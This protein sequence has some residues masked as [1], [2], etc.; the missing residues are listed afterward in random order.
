MKLQHTLVK[1]DTGP[2]ADEDK[3][4]A[5]RSIINNEKII[6]QNATEVHNASFGLWRVG[7]PNSGYIQSSSS[8]YNSNDLGCRTGSPRLE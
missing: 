8:F 2:I 1:S 4:T 7:R 6:V 3:R 5:S